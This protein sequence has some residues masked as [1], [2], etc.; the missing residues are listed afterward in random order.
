MKPA[1]KRVLIV[2]TGETLPVVAADYGDFE[3]WITR[4][5]G[6]AKEDVEVASV[7]RGDP[8]PAAES[9]AAVVVTGSPGMVTERLDWSEA[10]A[11]WL[12]TAVHEDSVPIFGICYGHQLLAHGLGGLVAKN[13]N[14]REMG[15]LELTVE[16]AG[17]LFENGRYPGHFSHVESVLELP[18]DAR[19]IAQTQLDP[20][21]AI[22]FG[23]R[24]WGVQFHPEFDVP[25]TRG[26]V[27]ARRDILCSEGFD[28]DAM[29]AD[30][31][32]TPFVSGVL[33]RFIGWVFSRR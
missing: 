23:P 20:H 25:I 22:E 27:E 6:L 21:A 7:F 16:G 19:A 9:V 30:V 24:Q 3:A 4:G 14:G 13:P 32:E 33:S 2:K 18:S 29:I 10:A 15:T 8:L 17:L 11:E 31:V 5:M 1:R 12:A 26:Y 28:P